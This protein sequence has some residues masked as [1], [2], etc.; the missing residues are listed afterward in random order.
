V[1]G[2]NAIS[3]ML[4]AIV[5]WLPKAVVAIVLIVVASAIAKVVR[6]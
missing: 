4:D 3:T 5:G 1:F 6:T 2:A